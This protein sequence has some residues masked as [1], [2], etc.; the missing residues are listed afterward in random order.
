M[1]CVT[2]L[3]KPLSDYTREELEGIVA[4]LV[5][6]VHDLQSSKNIRALAL[7]RLE[8]SRRGEQL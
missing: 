8:M 2:W 1:K 5:T 6:K 7:G 4:A 3:G